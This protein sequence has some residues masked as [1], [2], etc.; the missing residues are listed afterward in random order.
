[1][2]LPGSCWHR[3]RGGADINAVVAGVILLN[4]INQFHCFKGLCSQQQVGKNDI[5]TT[6]VIAVS[7]S[8]LPQQ[9]LFGIIMNHKQTLK[10]LVVST[11][12][13]IFF[14]GLI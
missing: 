11:F 13:L 4:E 10:C 8:A 3:Q 7:V 1:M 6:G 5:T 2:L 9:T 14:F 12:L